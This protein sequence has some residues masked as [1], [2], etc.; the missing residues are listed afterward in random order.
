MKFTLTT[1][2]AL[3]WIAGILIAG[4]EVQGYS[5]QLVSSTAGVCL[6][7]LSSL[8]IIKILE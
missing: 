5:M 8:A 1:I 3:G 4:A 2:F 7:A 6:F